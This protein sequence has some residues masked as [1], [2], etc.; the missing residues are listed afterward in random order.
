[1]QNNQNDDMSGA[2]FINEK[3]DPEKRH[4]NYT[5]YVTI[6]EVKYRLAG[7][8]H[9]ASTSGKTFLAIKVSIDEQ[10]QAQTRKQPPVPPTQR[11]SAPSTF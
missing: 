10:K 11:K 4:P 7:W 6:N 9:E 1:M 5:G 3:C 2:L 8:K